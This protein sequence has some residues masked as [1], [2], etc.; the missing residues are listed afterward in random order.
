MRLKAGVIAAVLAAAMTFAFVGSASAQENQAQ[1]PGECHASYDPCVPIATDVDCAS[2]DGDGP[3]FIDY[4][5]QVLGED[6]YDLDR[7]GT[8]IGCENET[9][10]GPPKPEPVPEPEP[11]PVPQ[12]EPEPAPEPA[13]P[14]AKAVTAEPDFTG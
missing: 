1:A 7:E 8:G 6:A 5:V 12:P 13:A 10:S 11:E 4:P 2:G 14:P 3:V 9:G